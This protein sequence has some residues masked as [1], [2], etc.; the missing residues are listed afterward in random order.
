MKWF[1]VRIKT[2]EEAED[3]ISSFLYDL[4]VNGVVVEDDVIDNSENVSWDYIDESLLIKKDYALIRAYFPENINIS[5]VVYQIKEGLNYIGRFLDVGAKEVEISQIDEEDWANEWKK[6]YK[7]IE[8]DN[9]AIVPS[10][11]EYK[12]EKNRII[13][14]LDPGMAFGTGTHET[15]AMCIKLL[16]KYI[17]SGQ[18]IIDVG[19]G[20]GILSIAAKLLGAKNVLA[21]D[22]DDVAVKSCS[23]NVKL[24]NV[25]IEIKKNNLIEGIDK[26]FDVVIANIVADIIIKLSNK[27]KDVL[28]ENS[29]FLTSGI[30]KDRLSDVEKA[31]IENGFEIIEVLNMN[32]WYALVS[33]VR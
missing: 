16:Q 3:A 13:I 6:Y 25:D 29:I 14:R 12:N 1:E 30:I 23:E 4:G 26:K 20:T 24:N 32:D 19:C 8:I 9:I 11:E 28:K 2:K 21:V 18:E 10:W 22:I 31:L 7:P 15:T 5:E 33:K 27:V 17:K